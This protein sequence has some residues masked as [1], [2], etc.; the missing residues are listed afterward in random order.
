MRGAATCFG[1]SHPS[2]GSYCMCFDK[3][4]SII[5]IIIVIIIITL[6]PWWWLWKTETCS[7]TSHV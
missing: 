4:I 1:F 5:I 7:S 3:V 2:S 6:A